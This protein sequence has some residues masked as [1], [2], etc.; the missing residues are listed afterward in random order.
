MQSHISA[1]LVKTLLKRKHRNGNALPGQRIPVH[2][3]SFHIKGIGQIEIERSISSLLP[4]DKICTAPPWSNL[5][6]IIHNLPQDLIKLHLFSIR[7]A[8]CEEPDPFL[9]K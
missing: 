7:S 8:N 4:V 9:P 5:I 3:C 2:E 1:N 6:F